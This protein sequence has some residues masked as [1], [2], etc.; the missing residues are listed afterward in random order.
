MAMK[1]IRTLNGKFDARCKRCF[2]AVYRFW[3]DDRPPPSGCTEGHDDEIAMCGAVWN[4]LV[5]VVIAQDHLRRDLAP[6]EAFL[7]AELGDKAN[8]LMADIRAGKP[9]PNHKPTE[10]RYDQ[11]GAVH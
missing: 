8:A 10:P 7:L 4:A 1:E 2:K 11:T 3:V 6:E 9:A 5:S